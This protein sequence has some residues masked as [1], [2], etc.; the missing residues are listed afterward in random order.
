MSRHTSA[1]SSSATAMVSGSAEIVAAFCRLIGTSPTAK[2]S[3]LP[4]G[5]IVIAAATITR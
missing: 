4:K 1:P 2:R 5:A 3:G